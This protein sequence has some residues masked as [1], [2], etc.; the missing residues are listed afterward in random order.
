MCTAMILPKPD[1][2]ELRRRCLP[3]TGQL[4]TGSK[5]QKGFHLE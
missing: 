5:P 1:Q 4:N 3:D 2:E